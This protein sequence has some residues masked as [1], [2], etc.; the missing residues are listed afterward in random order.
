RDRGRVIFLP[1]LARIPTGDDRYAMSD[2]LQAGVRRALGV[3]AEGR[4]PPWIAAHA[5]PG[6]DERARAVDKARDALDS[7]QSAL[8]EAER[9]YDELARYQ[10]LLWQEGVGIEDVVLEALRLMGFEAYASDRTELT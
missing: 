5:L 2:S 10:R 4:P 8:D 9:T 6:L 7:A 1:A 3:V